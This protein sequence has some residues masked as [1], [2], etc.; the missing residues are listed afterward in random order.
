MII[1]VLFYQSLPDT[2][3]LCGR[4]SP[5]HVWDYLNKMKQSATRVGKLGSRK[6]F[7]VILQYYTNQKSAN[8]LCIETT[9]DRY[10]SMVKVMMV[11]RPIEKKVNSHYFSIRTP[12]WLVMFNC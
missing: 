9:R 4:I 10:L 2:I 12:A 6:I 8:F 3:S 5:E 1:V 11:S 7:P